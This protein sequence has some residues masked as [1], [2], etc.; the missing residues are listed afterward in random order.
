[1]ADAKRKAEELAAQQQR[2]NERRAQLM[3]ASAGLGLA[4]DNMQNNLGLYRS[5]VKHDM[6]PDLER[7]MDQ[8]EQER[9]RKL[10][11]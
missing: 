5:A 3:K 10:G 6:N 7:K 11:K 9:L 8:E 1:M 4:I 2:E